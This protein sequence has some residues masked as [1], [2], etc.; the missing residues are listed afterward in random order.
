MWLLDPATPLT[1]RVAVNRFWAQLFGTGLVE[2]EEDSGTQGTYPSHPELLDWLALHFRDDLDWDMKALLKTVVMSSTYQQS[3]KVTAEHLERDPNNRL[4]AR[5]PRFRLE[6]EMVRDQALAVAGLLSQKMYRPSVFPPQPPG[7]WRS[8]VN[9]ERTWTTSTGEDRYRRGAYTFLLRS[10]PYPSMITFDAPNREIYTI[11]RI[12]TNTPLQAFITMNDPAYVEIAQALARRII[13][14]GGDTLDSR[15]HFGLKLCLLHEP[16]PEQMDSVKKL[17]HGELTHF[18][19]ASP[20][21]KELA[22]DPL[23]QLPDGLP[24]SV[25]ET[26]AWTVVATVLLTLDAMMM[27]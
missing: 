10:T 17:Y 13:T 26:A 8:A 3:N 20:E 1:P 19:S 11:R 9:G 24:A 18:Q 7:L 16:A 25:A 15:L 22:T 4:F 14:E 23:G 21:A 6:A 2:T 5:K 27:K 12:P